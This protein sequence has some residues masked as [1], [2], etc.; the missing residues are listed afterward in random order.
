M[1]KL[2]RFLDNHLEEMF[3][4]C[5]LAYL[6]L[7]VNFEVFRR[8]IL[9]NSGAYTEEAIRLAL[10][11]MVYLGV[12]YIIKKRKHIACDIFSADI[13]PQKDFILSTLGNIFFLIFSC[14]MT[15]ATFHLI[16]MQL[17][18]DKKTEAMHLPIVYFTSILL[19]GF[20]LSIFRL[21]QNMYE[22]I[23]KLRKTI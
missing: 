12:P 3:I 16:E 15:Y 20:G 19:I 2:L 21:L 6:V 10:I 7:G 17:M 1:I 22:D 11:S 8:Y 23:N 13:S 4:A 18:L 14:I 9:N 5:L